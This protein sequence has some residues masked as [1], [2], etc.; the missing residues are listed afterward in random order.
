MCV[1]GG[2][3]GAKAFPQLDSILIHNKDIE[4]RTYCISKLYIWDVFSTLH[5]CLAKPLRGGW[6]CLGSDWASVVT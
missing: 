6:G 1:G 2:E 5:T 4:L 3:G